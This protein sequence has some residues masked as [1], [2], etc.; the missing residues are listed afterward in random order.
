M[1]QLHLDARLAAGVWETML[2]MLWH[3]KRFGMIA[4]ICISSVDLLSIVM[5]EFSIEDLE[6]YR[7]VKICW[8]VLVW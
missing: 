5:Q 3:L 4:V 6:N 7:I 8:W 1:V 2:P